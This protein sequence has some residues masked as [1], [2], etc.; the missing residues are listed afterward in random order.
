M[1][2]KKR[3]IHIIPSLG[4]GGAESFLLRLIPLMDEE[5]IV[6]T[7]YHT[8]YDKERIKNKKLEYI[9][10]DPARTSIEDIKTF[11][12][13][14]FSL[15]VNDTILS[16][17]YIADLFA[18]FLKILLFWKKFKIIW[19]IRN[20]VIT[21]NEYSLFAFIAFNILRIFLMQIPKSIIF[22]S[23]ESMLQHLKK[24]YSKEKSL[25][26]YNGF[27]KYV[28][29][30]KSKN[31][32]DDFNIIYVARYHPQK[33]HK[34]LFK[35][36]GIFKQKYSFNFKLHLVGKGLNTK[37]KILIKHLKNLNI[38]ENAILYDLINPISVHKLFSKSD[39]SLLLSTYGESFP[40]VIAEAMLYG[41]FPIA[42]N[43]GDTKSIIE[44]FG[45]TVSKNTSAERIATLIF[46]YYLLKNKNFVEW[47]KKKKECQDFANNRFSIESSANKF[48]E[49]IYS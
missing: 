45:D 37:N 11:L 23:K 2:I 43:V 1:N 12:E 3:N 35:A 24:G 10:L 28:P 44:S 19:N 41:T 32:K 26:I 17:L 40:N 21:I 14:I 31:K 4:Y 20:T 42:T 46:K 29:I 6:I 30:K 47:E 9:T 34:L 48:K 13:L 15:N 36:I 27:K 16:W 33:N 39:I 18:S 49:I 8:Q 38:Y 5:N 22:N 25:I 7:L